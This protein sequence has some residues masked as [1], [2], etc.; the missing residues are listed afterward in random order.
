MAPTLHDLRQSQPA[1]PADSID[2]LR[3][4][5]LDVIVET[6]AD[7]YR[8]GNSIYTCIAMSGFSMNC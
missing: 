3:L 4:Q 6:P 8:S 2:P 5:G 1:E 7:V